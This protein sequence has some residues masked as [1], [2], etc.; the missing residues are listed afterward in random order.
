MIGP[1]FFG[2]ASCLLVILSAGLFTSHR[3]TTTTLGAHFLLTVASQDPS[4]PSEAPNANAIALSDSESSQP[5]QDGEPI[6]NNHSVAERIAELKEIIESDSAQLAELERELDDPQS[7]YAVAEKEYRQ[8]DQ[9][10]ESIAAKIESAKAVNNLRL[11]DALTKDQQALE[12]QRKLAQDRFDL[13]IESRKNLREKL[14]TLRSKLTKDQA[15]LD[16]LTGS[17]ELQADPETMPNAAA[18]TPDSER[19][20]GSADR[21]EPTS[22]MS[23]QAEGSTE[24]T[25]GDEE[26]SEEE[27]EELKQVE[28]EAEAKEKEAQ[29]AEQ[30]TRS[31]ESRMADIQK[32]VA[33]EQRE[34]GLAKR[35][36]DL[37]LAAQQEYLQE[38]QQLQADRAP[39][40]EVAEMKIL[41]TK[42]GS[43]VA[44]ARTE[45]TEISERLNEHRAELSMLQSEHII[46]LQEAKVRAQEAAEA[47]AKVE[48]LRN[49][50]APR[51][52]LQWGLD[53]GPRLL[54]ILFGMFVLNRILSFFSSRSIQLITSGTGR[55]SKVD[56]E[57]R[58]KTLV[59]VF[60]NAATVAIFVSGTLMLL[61]EIGANITVLMGGV[62][63]I[64]LAVAFGAQNLIKD[65]FYGFVMLLE[66][67]YMLNDT[68][69]IGSLSGQVE[70]ITL[71]MTVLRD[72]N[73]IVHFI[74]NGTI[75]SVSNE[76]HGWSRAV[77]EVAVSYE[78]DL[79]RIHEIIRDVNVSLH[80]DAKYG[81]FMLESPSDPV[82]EAMGE[83]SLTLRTVVK[84]MPNKHGGIKQ[85]WLR[86]VQIA[87]HQKGIS[88]P[89]PRRLATVR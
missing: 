25:E 60:Q 7:E 14:L 1:H 79:E 63:V 13:A 40:S 74:P 35:K 44:E 85:E 73:G 43:R 59:G 70:R 87:F 29:E 5:P 26:S 89:Y 37:A 20:P 10:W 18:V 2:I 21:A 78:E 4:P 80:E 54:A 68:I 17:D 28:A 41:V 56:R 81:K 24:R 9:E 16:D 61:E 27:D 88:P 45:T 15:A 77:C 58:A 52:L 84:T 39:A 71:R 8:L 47:E 3:P 55:G 82:I 76:T 23:E 22:E 62:A 48:F 86:R 69:R 67:Q 34:V 64:G 33:Q 49:P 46:A 31:I 83:T 6:A 65:Y 11:L 32:L 72:S 75:N 51:N 19:N 66:N 12:R 57:N 53:H 50:F 30:E 36:L 42:A 38:L